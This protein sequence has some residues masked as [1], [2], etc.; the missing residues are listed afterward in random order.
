VI[1]AVEIAGLPFVKKIQAVLLMQTPQKAY[2]HHYQEI[3]H[4]QQNEITNLSHYERK[5]VPEQID[6]FTEIKREDP[7]ESDKKGN[8]KKELYM[9][10]NMYA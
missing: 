6:L 7:C 4:R 2:R 1:P 10:E 9:R 8:V 5:H 3:D